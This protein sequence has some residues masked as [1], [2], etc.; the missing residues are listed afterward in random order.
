MN[1]RVGLGYDVHRLTEGRKLILGGA[2]IPYEK[3]LLGHSDADVVIHAVMDAMTGAVKLGDIGRLFPDNDPAYEGISSRILLKKVCEL[4][5][6]KG[7]EIVNVDAVIIA[8]RPKMSP[9]VGEME[10]NLA[11]DM[12]VDVDCI[13]IKATTEEGLGFTGRGEGIAAQAVVLV[14]KIS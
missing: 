12:N 13:N 9:F 2:Y 5:N 7:Y 8:Q 11:E 1:I 3:G 10:K 14:K 4:L 6:E